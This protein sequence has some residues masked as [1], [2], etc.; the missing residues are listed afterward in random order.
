[1]SHVLEYEVDGSVITTNDDLIDGRAVRTSAGLNPASAHVLIRID[2]GRSL[3]CRYDTLSS[4][5][6]LMQV[7][8]ACVIVLRR[9][10]RAAATVRKLD[11]LRFLLADIS[12]VSVSAL[13][14]GAVRIDRSNRRW[15][16]LYGL[17]RLFLKREWQGTHRS[18]EAAQGITL[19]FPM[20]DL[21]E[22]YVAALLKKALRPAG[23]TVET[24][25]GRLFCLLEEGPGGRKRFQT[26]PDIIVR[27]GVGK[28]EK[29]VSIIDTKWK[30]LSDVVEDRKHG[31]SQSDVY[32]LMSYG[33]LYDCAELVLL[34]PH[35]A[36]LGPVGVAKPYRVMNSGDRLHLRSVD[37]S[38][39]EADIIAQLVSMFQHAGRMSPA[40]CDA[41]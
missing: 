4:D 33:R 26:K 40:T 23:L 31:V 5:I 36:G 16:T 22:A 20:N 14:W 7:M 10:A 24:Q 27:S 3:A 25:G 12:D 1:M 35:H 6:A 9:H 38:L 32:Q 21:F 28:G 19:L 17:A 8:K 34:Y 29:T 39:R 11:E 30:R 13:A 41:A 15:E 2:G 37:V 18:L